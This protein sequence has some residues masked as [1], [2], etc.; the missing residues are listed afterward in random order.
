VSYGYDEANGSPQGVYGNQ[1]SVTQWLNTGT[2]P[3]SQSVFN[4]QGMVV[5]KIDPK[6]NSTAI[7]YDSTGLYATKIQSPDTNG[8]HHIDQF[9][10]DFN[11]GLLTSHTDQNGQVTSVAYDT[12]E[13]PI[14]VVRPD[15]GTVTRC[16]S[17]EG[18]VA[19]Y[20]SCS[21]SSAPYSSVTTAQVAASLNEVSTDLF[22]GLGRLNQHQ[23]DSDPDGATYTDT[24][25]DALGRAYKNSNPHRSQGSSTDGTVQNTFDGLGRVISVTEQDG[26][27]ATTDYSAFPCVTVRDEAG[28]ARKT[29]SDALGRIA[30]VFEDP[31][32]V[33]YETDYQ[34]D[35]LGNLTC[36]EQH[37]GVSGTGCSAN[38]SNDATSPWRVRRF[39]YDSLSRL[40]TAT[41][42]ESGIVQYA[43]DADSN[44]TSK[45]SPAQ[46]GASGT[47][48]IY[49]CFDALN[50]LTAKDY[51]SQTCSSPAATYGYDAGANGIGRRTSM[52]DS[53]GSTSWSYDVMGRMISESR[54]ILGVNKTISATY[55]YDGSLAS[56]RYPSGHVVNYT[57]GGAGRVLSV[58]DSTRSYPFVGG[59]NGGGYVSYTPTGA[60]SAAT[61]GGKIDLTNTY[62][63]RLQPLT[64]Q[65]NGLGGT[66]MSRTYDF[67]VG[68]NNGAVHGIT[69]GLDSFSLPGRPIGSATFVYDTLNRLAQAQSTGTDCSSAGS[70]TMNWGNTYTVDPWGN[71]TN[72]GPVTGLTGCM[73]ESLSQS[74][75]VNNRISGTNVHD[76][77]GNMIQNG[78][79]VYDKENRLSSAGGVT[80]VYDGDGERVAKTGATTM[81]YWTGVSNAIVAESDGSGN[82]TSEYVFFNG[83]RLSRIDSPATTPVA[84][85]YVADNLGSA[86]VIANEA[87]A[88]EREEMYFP[89]GGERWSQGS[90]TNRYKFTGKERD[91]ESAGIVGGDGLDYFG[92]RYYSTT[93]RFLSPDWAARPT[94]VPYAVFG[95]PQSLNLYGYVRND[96]LSRIDADGHYRKSPGDCPDYCPSHDLTQKKADDK[97]AQQQEQKP[98]QAP[99]K[100]PDGKPTPPPVPVPGAPNLPWKWYPNPQNPRGGIWGPDGWKGPNPPNGSWDPDGHWDINGGK[101]QPVDHYD[102][103]GNPITPDQAHP[104]NRPAI[105]PRG[106]G[107]EQ[108][109]QIQ[110]ATAE[111][112]TVGTVLI[113][114]YWLASELN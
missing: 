24:S 30:K 39:T 97:E 42:P 57:P 61:L 5:Q 45:A 8:V 93:G 75:G 19:G 104:G 110:N 64:L 101:G 106:P 76:A 1:T 12:V 29:C 25:Y 88:L 86:T 15:T 107:P 48:T 41:N 81:L 111:T 67:G 78:A 37:G 102:P 21:Q 95:D 22:D 87:G 68:V 92:A 52:T 72:K 7:T 55:N 70:T 74:V 96:P 6:G 53:S 34:Y 105:T 91:A 26:S 18:A 65:A 80:Y 38:P 109:R 31:S 77:A 83:G 11:T 47:V 43:Y 99:P 114:L 73:T 4:S 82:L 51:A 60:L 108:Q 46:N 16:Y 69:D 56:V 20:L 89:Y 35:A 62:N 84:H 32:G 59:A 66:L 44:V 103:K 28:H 79:L 58:Y 63:Q 36:A 33:N 13:R 50:R 85:Y 71:L 40:L 27:I 3:K 49:Y 9:A 17:D 23:L 10:Y 100:G 94:A 112:G 54:T 90:D 98:P 113:I 2:S 14:Q